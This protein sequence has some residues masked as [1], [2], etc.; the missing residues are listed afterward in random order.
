MQRGYI[1]NVCV[2]V[3]HGLERRRERGHLNLPLAMGMEESDE[4]LQQP[5]ET[6][7]ISQ[8]ENSS[9][10]STTSSSI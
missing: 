5:M 6:G 4:Y 1:I 10:L 8:K 9:P 7:T 3:T 2:L